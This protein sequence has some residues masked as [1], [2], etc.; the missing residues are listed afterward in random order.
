MGMGQGCDGN[1]MGMEQGWD[2]SGTGPGQI[3]DRMGWVWNRMGQDGM[4]GDMK[5]GLFKE[6]QNDK[7]HASV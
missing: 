5:R 7:S 6:P 1:G 3:Q 4:G 2:R